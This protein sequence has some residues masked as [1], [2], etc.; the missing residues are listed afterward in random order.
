MEIKLE[1]LIALYE[2]ALVTK[3]NNP[4]VYIQLA[5]LYYAKGNLDAA[6]DIHQKALQIQSNAD[7]KTMDNLLLTHSKNKADDNELYNWIKFDVKSAMNYPKGM[8]LLCKGKLDGMLIE[9][10]FSK[11]EMARV[12]NRIESSKYTKT[13]RHYGERIG[14]SFR[15]VNQDV[16]LYFRKSI[17]FRIQLE[18]IFENCF[19]K[20]VLSI[21]NKISGS[22]PVELLKES[23]E[24]LFVPAEIRIIHPS[25]E[26]T[27]AHTENETFEKSK[28]CKYLKQIDKKVDIL[29][30]FIVVEKPE[31]GGE[32]VLYNLL[33]QQTMSVMKKDC[34]DQRDYY[35]ER[36]KKQYI[37]PE[38]GDMVIFN[39][40]RIW[41]KVAGCE[42]NKN[43]ITV[44]GFLARS[45]D[46]KT[47]FCWV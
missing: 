33:W 39:A 27:K 19:E 10:A 31:K 20:K 29:S 2:K 37:N 9:Q 32:L 1:Q 7:N 38:V 6:F 47:V 22:R 28:E 40:G 41:H 16:A 30:Y 17:L 13:S 26:E 46:D 15:D 24:N 14:L 5:E 44:G 3:P 4:L 23:P 45:K 8:D 25:K 42:G 12:K 36:F 18:E 43:R 11:E 34:S 21:L 35:L